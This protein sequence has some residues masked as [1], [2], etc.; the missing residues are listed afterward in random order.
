MQKAGAFRMAAELGIAIIAPDTSPRGEGVADDAS[1]DLGQGAGFYLNATQAP[2]SLHYHM[3][4]YV[5][6]ELPAII[7]ANFGIGCEI[8]L[9]PQHGRTRCAHHWP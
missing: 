7:E 2:W 4:D 8:N 9:W 3:Y 5:T 6:Q 1:Y